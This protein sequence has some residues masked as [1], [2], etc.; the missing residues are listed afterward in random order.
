[1]RARENGRR[2]DAP[3]LEPVF[4]GAIM[5]YYI[6][7]RDFSYIIHIIIITIYAHVRPGDTII[8]IL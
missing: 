3:D 7:L 1:M 6:F 8:I 4:R 2:N 5:R